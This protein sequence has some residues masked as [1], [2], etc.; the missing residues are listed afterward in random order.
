[1]INKSGWSS[2]IIVIYLGDN[3][4]KFPNFVEN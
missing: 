3:D 1:M 4:L 2:L